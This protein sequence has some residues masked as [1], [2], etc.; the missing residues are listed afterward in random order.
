[1]CPQKPFYSLHKVDSHVLLEKTLEFSFHLGVHQEVKK[2]VNVKSK[3]EGF[4]GRTVCRIG[5]VGNIATEEAW[6]ISILAEPDFLQDGFNLDIPVSR[7]TKEAVERP[8]QQPVFVL[9]GIWVPDRWF[10][11]SDFVR[12]EDALTEGIHA[13]A[14]LKCPVLL[15]GHADNEAHGVG[16]EDWGVLILLGSVS[17][18]VIP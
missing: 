15:D 7:T 11:D 13:I 4:R 9:F 14:L 18:L 3:G 16:S 17:V 2:V 5:W 8:F 10:D 1:M 12:R 6:V